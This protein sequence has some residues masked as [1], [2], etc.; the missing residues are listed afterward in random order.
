MIAKVEYIGSDRTAHQLTIR[1]A[2]GGYPPSMDIERVVI[3][4]KDYYDNV[5]IENHVRVLEEEGDLIYPPLDYILEGAPFTINSKSF[6]ITNNLSP[7]TA[8]CDGVYD[9]SYSIVLAG[10]FVGTGTAGQNV[11]FSTDTEQFLEYDV[12]YSKGR[13]YRIDKTKDTVAGAVIWLLDFLEEDLTSF[14]VGYQ[15][16]IKIFIS[17]ATLSKTV[18]ATGISATRFGKDRRDVL[19]AQA[20]LQAANDAFDEGDTESAMT[21]ISYSDNIVSRLV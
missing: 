12:I 20:Y 6:G 21:F 1:D 16:T 7:L 5:Y 9:L 4:L 10:D 8:F 19:E 17:M 13:V 18:L 2:A 11:I 3:S 15:D 14:Q